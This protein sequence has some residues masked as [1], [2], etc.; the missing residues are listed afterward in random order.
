MDNVKRIE[1]LLNMY[2]KQNKDIRDKYQNNLVNL[3]LYEELFNYLELDYVEIKENNLFISILFNTIYGNNIY[4]DRFYSLLLKAMVS[5]EGR[6][7]L[8]H[9]INMIKKD[10]D[11][12]MME[13]DGLVQQIERNK[14]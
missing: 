4:G 5:K 3:Q 11:N 1:E 7:E 2:L 9:F 14:M 6:I 12:L 13:N 8:K 10:Y